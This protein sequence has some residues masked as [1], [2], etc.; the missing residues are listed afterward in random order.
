MAALAERVKLTVAPAVVFFV[1]TMPF[2]VPPDTDNG[3]VIDAGSLTVS[4]PTV[5]EVKDSQEKL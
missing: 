1:H 3:D 2:W 5:P 4:V